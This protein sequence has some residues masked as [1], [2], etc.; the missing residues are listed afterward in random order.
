MSLHPPSSI[1]NW[2]I[3]LFPSSASNANPS[4]TRGA[5]PTR[6][7]GREQL[8][9]LNEAP[10]ILQPRKSYDGTTFCQAQT[11]TFIV[12][13][14]FNVANAG[15]SSFLNTCLNAVQTTIDN[16]NTGLIPS[17]GWRGPLG[18]NGLSMVV[19][20]EHDF[21]TTYGVLHSAIQ[22]LVGWMSSNENTFGT[23]AFTIWDGE[24]Q[25][26]HGSING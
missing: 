13:A 10:E 14:S 5:S 8:A 15:V 25:V 17:S 21:Q 26:G 23:V 9:P 18:R 2:P 1:A 3:Q 11:N 6:I 24:N 12:V 16:G 22:A 7:K 19:W 20:S 4:S